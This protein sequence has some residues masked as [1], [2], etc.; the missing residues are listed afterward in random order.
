[1]TNKTFFALVVDPYRTLSNRKVEI[2]CFMCFQEGKGTNSSNFY[3][4]IPLYKAEDFGIH[5]S[6]YYKLEHN[7]FQSKFEAQIVKLIYKNYW[8][9]T[10]SSNFLL[11]NDEYYT[12]QVEDMSAKIKNYQLK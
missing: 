9:D 7:Y 10:L 12:K 1:M 4:S 6:K 5:A 2:G 8:L 3:E 11:T